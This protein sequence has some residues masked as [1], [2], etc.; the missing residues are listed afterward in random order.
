MMTMP[1][2][3]LGDDGWIRI[4]GGKWKGFYTREEVEKEVVP[5]I[6]RKALEKRATGSADPGPA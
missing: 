2:D 5:E 1:S 6:F 3:T 4:V